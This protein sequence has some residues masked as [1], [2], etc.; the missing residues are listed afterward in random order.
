M[1]CGWAYYFIFVVIAMI[2]GGFVSRYSI[3]GAGV[4]TILVLVFATWFFPSGVIY[5]IGGL[6]ITVLYATVFA[7]IFVGAVMVLRNYF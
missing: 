7:T 6:N 3:E 4:S 5:F 2:I 1:P